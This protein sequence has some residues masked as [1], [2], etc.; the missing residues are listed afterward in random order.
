MDDDT[1]IKLE[2][3]QHIPQNAST[4]NGVQDQPAKQSEQPA[5]IADDEQTITSEPDNTPSLEYELTWDSLTSSSPDAKPEPALAPLPASLPPVAPPATIKKTRRGRRRWP[6]WVKVV[7]TI[8]LILLVSG[9]GAAGYGY[10]FY[11][12]NIQK[13][14]QKIIH[15]VSLGK[16]E[17]HLKVQPLPPDTAVTGRSWNILLLG[18]DNDQKYTFPVILTQVMMVVHID[19]VTNSVTLVSIPRDSW[20]NVPEIGGTHKIDQAFFLGALQHNSFDD[21][22]RI[23]RETIENDY[24]ITI[25]RYAWVGLSGFSNVINT[26]GGVDVDVTHPI[27][28]DNYPDDTGKNANN[29]YALQR[30]NLAPGPQHLNG[31]QA[32]EYVRSRHADLVGDIGRTVRQQQVLEALKL[33]LNVTNV[34]SNLHQLIA[35][36]TGNVYTDLTEQEMIGFAVYG[37]DLNNSAIHHLTLGPGPGSQDYGDFGTVYDPSV[38]AQQDIVIPHCQNIQPIINQIFGLGNTQ[39]CNVSG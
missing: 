36:L 4:S 19:T 6:K 11:A 17:Q 26:L 3:P 7:V 35:D 13:P 15:P 20:V 24:G 39:S 30:L 8:F 18:S 22:V 9:G 23:A 34:L 16:G 1:T 31:D 32:L 10:Y 12:T 21:G 2:R 33:K 38:G 29:P 27:V 28:D 5:A 25:D 37:H 14:L